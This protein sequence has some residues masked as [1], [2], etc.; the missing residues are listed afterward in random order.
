MALVTDDAKMSEK[1][2]LKISCHH[3][4]F[5]GSLSVLKI[6]TLFGNIPVSV[7]LEWEN[8]YTYIHLLY[9][10]LFCSL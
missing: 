9:T 5:T 10:G 7:E 2:H 4:W 8:K 1:W 3:F 6:Q